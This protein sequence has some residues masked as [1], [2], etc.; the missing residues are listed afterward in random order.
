[1]AARRRP[2]AEAVGPTAEP[3]LPAGAGQI[4][5]GAEA[6]ETQRSAPVPAPLEALLEEARV[7]ANGIL[8]VRGWAV[9]RT[10]VEQI[11][12]FLDGRPLGLA[13]KSVSRHDVGRA[14]PDY[15]DSC[16]SGFLFHQQLD[17]P[18]REGRTLKVVIV[19]AGGIVGQMTTALTVPAAVQPAD[20]PERMLRLHCDAASLSENGVLT[21][22]GWAVCASGIDHI[23]IA[24]DDE[25]AGAAEIGFDR[26]DVGNQFPSV[27]A[28]RR[29]GFRFCRDLGKRCEG[30]HLLRVS[31]FG[32]AG[33]MEVHHRLLRAAAEIVAPPLA[34]Y[35]QRAI[36]CYLDTPPVADGMAGEKV[37]GF[38][39]LAGWAISPCGIAGVEVFV[40]G[41]SLGEAYF[42]VR[43]E[44]I[45]AAFPDAEGSLLSG[46]AM[47][48]PPQAMKPGRHE[49]RVAIRDRGGAEAAI[50]FTIEA[51]PPPETAG[52]S[53]PRRKLPQTEIDLGLR[54]LDA[55][56]WRPWNEL[57]MPVTHT[58]RRDVEN[59]RRTLASLR[60]QAYPDWRLTVAAVPRDGGAG[61]ATALLDGFEDIRERIAIRTEAA[62]FPL[63]DLA[64]TDRYPT[65]VSL[66][67]PGDT[68]GADALLEIALAGA[69]GGEA[70]FL[71]SDERRVDPADGVTKA[72]FK[73]DWSP[74]LLLST[75]YIGRLWAATP[76]LLARADAGFAEL[77]RHGEYD[78]VL[79]LTEQAERIVH[80]PKVLCARGPVRIDTAETE[81]RALARALER[82]H[83]AAAIG[84]G[85][86]AGNYRVKRKLQTAGL[87]SIIIPTMASR[88]LI[89]TA[90]A[91]IREKTHYRRFEIICLDNIPDH[92]EFWK[93]WLRQHADVVVAV[94]EPFNWSRFNNLGAKHA[95]GEFLLFL[96]DDIEVV[97]GAWLDGLLEQ[98]QRPEVG[99]VGPQLLYP[100]GKV[101]HAG[102]FLSRTVARH[103]F[104]FA[105]RDEPGPFGLALT[106]RN[107]IGVTGACLLVRRTVFE[108]LGGFDESH[109]II[110]NDVD[111]CL[112]V[113]RSGRLVVYTPYAR[114]VHH[115]MA[116]RAEVKDAYGNEQFAGEWRDLFLRGDPYFNPYLAIDYDDY[117]AEAEPVEVMR[118]GPP[119]IAKE[120]IRRILAVKLD[121]IGDFIAAFPVFRRLKN[122]FPD[123]ELTVLAAGP[124]CALA[125][126]EPAIDRVIEFNYFHAVSSQ[127]IR[128]I[129]K[130][131][132]SRLERQ[133]QP[134]RFDL[135]VDLRRQ[136]DT[137]AVL[138]HTGARWLAGFDHRNTMGWLDIAVE[139]EGDAARAPKRHHV[140]AALLQLVDALA[141]S[142]AAAPVG[143]RPAAAPARARA[144]LSGLPGLAALTAAPVA[145]RRLI[146]VHAGAGAD[147]KKWPPASFAA[148]IDLLVA[149]DDA[150]VVMVGGADELPI[151]QQ[152]LRLVRQRQF[153]FSLVGRT[154][155]ADLPD[156]LSACDLFVG[157][158]SGPKHLAAALGV[159]TIGI[160]SGVVDA[161]EW[162]PL[163]PSAVAVRRRMSCSPCYLLDP[164][165]CHRRLACLHEI[166]VGDV[167]RACRRL[168]V[169]SRSPAVPDTTETG[170]EPAPL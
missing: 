71:Y 109:P 31:A 106:Q 16:N 133:L 10:A 140:T 167:Y 163:G 22:S 46:F 121:H 58:G 108:A 95:R 137:R 169:L 69:E 39:S 73:P 17:D 156:V 3:P 68:L 103:A 141:A 143:A 28:A 145:T 149:R 63:A 93:S 113:R 66:I 90:I 132:W 72:F 41:R 131:E 97:D 107:V 136:P 12:V 51:E 29:A 152:I 86:I 120:R 91:S 122:C 144:G 67:R 21:L 7:D 155:L 25:P 20:R 4:I 83:I 30:E 162:A 124:S 129:T 5:G 56:G 34:P 100:D 105:P 78:L 32:K 59:A 170:G 134:Y 61:L 102:M 9:S 150:A 142:C 135:A 148:L 64:E 139:W 52:P 104:R 117:A 157:N 154:R 112:R 165:D 11:G 45:R 159:P 96:N 15:P 49:I 88:G 161:A 84:D 27:P 166:G 14:Y 43:R 99:A 116:S 18:T 47:L 26:P 153:V 42:G 87:V 168:L 50:E 44:D 33:E 40:D 110:N 80:V 89:V 6:Q 57:L 62:D 101:Q 2:G 36:R 1:M 126:L 23:D 111:F 74:D 53:M 76:E 35:P 123:A 115:E 79:R 125:H 146:G 55:A 85:C 24:I 81:R 138:H 77:L 147:N 38:L 114:L 118:A 130:K 37:R 160:H 75:N 94:A 82:R 60:E 8:R 128:R 54:L 119:L 19:A 70:D 164:A 158:D 98:A 127:G 48:V 92:N 65:L 13:E 151:A